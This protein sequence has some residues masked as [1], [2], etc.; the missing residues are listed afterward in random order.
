M[1][2]RIVVV[3]DDVQT[4][5]LMRIILDDAGFDVVNLYHG[6]DAVRY[7]EK[8][9]ADLILLD[10]RLPGYDGFE[11]LE[12]MHTNGMKQTAPIIMLSA[13]V[14]S[15]SRQHAFDLG[16]TDFVNKP[17]QINDLLN[18]ITM[19]METAVFPWPTLSPNWQHA[20]AN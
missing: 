12:R 15:T 1:K 19:A 14:L 5:E 16:A 8:E 4:A 17:F 6:V 3:E 9:K 2:K 10:I 7:L 18:R 20:P 13:D 11:I